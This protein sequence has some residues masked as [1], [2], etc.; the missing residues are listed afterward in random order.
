MKSQCLNVPAL[1][2]ASALLA[3]GCSALHKSKMT[4]FE[5]FSENE[6]KMFRFNSLKNESVYPDDAAGE[7]VRMAWLNEYISDNNYCQNGFLI[8]SRQ[9]VKG[10]DVYGLR[11]S[12]YYVGKCK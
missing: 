3:S 2:L 7:S 8:L 4:S 6:Q 5:P 12:Y 1:C 9:F 11:E 10:G